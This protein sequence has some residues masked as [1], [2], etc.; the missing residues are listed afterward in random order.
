MFKSCLIDLPEFP[1]P[2]RLAAQIV[3]ATRATKVVMP[4]M[5]VTERIITPDTLFLIGG[6]VPNVNV[7]KEK[8]EIDILCIKLYS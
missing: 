5:R 1:L 4:A 6:P 8:E 7:L 3:I 2:N